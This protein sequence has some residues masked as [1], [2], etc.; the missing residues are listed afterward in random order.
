MILTV[1]VSDAKKNQDGLKVEA[2][3]WLFLSDGW[4]YHNIWASAAW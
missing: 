4:Y 2:D 1:R 3:D